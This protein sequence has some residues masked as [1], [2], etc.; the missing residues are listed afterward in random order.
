MPGSLFP[1]SPS[2]LPDQQGGD[3]CTQAASGVL[4]HVQPSRPTYDSDP[5]EAEA[6][7]SWTHSSAIPSADSSQPSLDQYV[8][9]WRTRSV[10][11][12]KDAVHRFN[13]T[14]GAEADFSLMLPSPH[15]SPAKPVSKARSIDEASPHRSSSNSALPLSTS[16][17]G[18]ERA[19]DGGNDDDLDFI[20]GRNSGHDG[21]YAKERELYAAREEQREHERVL[22][23]D[24]SRRASDERR[25]DKRRIKALE[26][27]VRRLKEELSRSQVRSS[28]PSSFAPPPP[29]PPPPPP[30]PLR[31]DTTPCTPT[32]MFATA[33]AS[34]R[35]AMTPVEAPIN[36]PGLSR[37][38]RQGQP[39]VNVPSEKMAAFLHEVKTAKLRRVGSDTNAMGG[40]GVAG[41]SGLSKSVSVT[42]SSA[43]TGPAKL[44]AKELL[45]RRSLAN[46]RVPIGSSLAAPVPLSAFASQKEPETQVGQ[47]RKADALGVDEV[48]GVP[49]KRRMTQLS[50]QSSSETSQDPT[51][52]SSG[53]LP[54]SSLSLP[55]RPL[56]TNETDITTPSLCSDNDRDENS[57][58]DRVPS[59]PP[60]PRAT[61]ATQKASKAAAREEQIEVIDVDMKED[62]HPKPRTISPNSVPR[63]ASDLFKKR[64]PTSPISIP[65]PRRPSAPARTK[66]GATPKPKSLPP[67]E[68][69]VDD[70][71]EAVSRSATSSISLTHPWKGRPRT[72]LPQ[73]NGHPSTSSGSGSSSQS[74]RKKSHKRRQ[75]LDE[76]IRTAEARSSDVDQCNDELDPE[77]EDVFT[78][79]GTKS[80]RR[81]FLAHGGG[82]GAPVFMGAGYVQGVTDSADEDEVT[83]T[84]PRRPSKSGIPRKKLAAVLVLLYEKGG[85]LRVLLTTRSKLLRAH[86]GQTALP[87]GKADETDT[88]LVYT[89]FRE[90]QEEVGLS[91]PSPDIHTLCTLQPFLSQ[92]QLIVTPVVALLMNP[93]I[94]CTLT[95][96]VGEVDH[97][98]NHPLEAILDPPLSEKEPLVPSGSEYWPYPEEFHNVTDQT[99]KID[100]TETVLYR[101][102]RLRSCASAV[103][104]LTAD[105]LICVAS[106]VYDKAT[107]YERHPP[108][109]DVSYLLDLRMKQY[110]TLEGPRANTVTVT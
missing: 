98:F 72:S 107:T 25:R 94:L 12:V 105:I 10:A 96:C 85:E 21:V 19:R 75:T 44:S 2:L 17:K 37:T 34:L 102:H 108:G 27:E 79:T 60:G 1:R 53:V 63:R 77:E 43:S 67:P 99:I 81:G 65:T 109:R 74:K 13:A 57:I 15:S 16:R 18:K 26:E 110:R 46:L 24:Q 42:T 41:P 90:A 82:G 70:E 49:S 76:E 97:I 47:K 3:Q 6:G 73:Q 35:H 69:D 51:A 39:T 89:A 59:T 50:F 4:I 48:T 40:D 61:A 62:L 11:S 14:E 88:D 86:P 101:H 95:P 20:V 33:R 100:E 8:S 83:G 22:S 54:L 78:A 104:G 30:L 45:R 58:E 52:S 91:L 7:P 5:G 103:K 29:P 80:K 38:K 84:H 106:I 64:P 87:G 28:P 55:P 93:A 66:R 56:P 71:D 36:N 32:S 31:I 92:S 9:P 23:G 68:S